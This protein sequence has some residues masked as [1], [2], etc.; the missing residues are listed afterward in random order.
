MK[1]NLIGIVNS[2]LSDMDSEAV[3]S[4]A[5]S[6]EA[7]Q[8]ARIV[9]D[10]FYNMIATRVIPEHSELLK[11]VAASDSAYPTHFQYGENVK[12]IVNLWYKDEDGYYKEVK[13]I[14]PM[15]FLSIT[16]KVSG[17]D[18]QS[19]ADK[20]GGTTLRI[21]NDTPPSFY[22]SFDD[23]WVIMDSFESLVDA[24]LQSSKVR[25]YGTVYPVFSL[26]DLYTPDIDATLFPYLIAE[27]KST[28]MSLLKG[29]SDPKIEQAARRQKSYM[30]NDM[31]RTSK[32]PQR[33][34]Y[35]RR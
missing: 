34:S 25:A 17:T 27:S 29:Q 22:T 7:E 4:I 16:D 14:E 2:I 23:N 3:N 30:Q 10:S 32:Q 5:D 12:E 9:R 31:Y 8:V 6:T 35:G 20:N 13:W 11:L 1:Q 26:E 21:R 15:D 24:T 33:P 28:A 18:F 19:V